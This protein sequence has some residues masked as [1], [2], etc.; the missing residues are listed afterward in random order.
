VDAMVAA[1]TGNFNGIQQ[2]EFN[3]MAKKLGFFALMVK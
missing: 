2:I 3:E 1:A